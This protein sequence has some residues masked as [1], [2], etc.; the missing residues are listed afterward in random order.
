M[1]ESEFIDKLLSKGEQ[2][3]DQSFQKGDAN[4][5]HATDKD[6]K[7]DSPS[8]LHAR[9]QMKKMLYGVKEVPTTTAGKK[10]ATKE[11]DITNVLF[12]W[13]A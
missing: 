10:K 6:V 12:N 4:E 7:K 3:T 13:L 9:R 5:D 11:V 8:R 1:K 2:Q